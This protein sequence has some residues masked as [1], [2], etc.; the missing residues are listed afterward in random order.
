M[1]LKA[2]VLFSI[3][4]LILANDIVWHKFCVTSVYL[5]LKERIVVFVFSKM[6]Y[7]T[8]GVLVKAF[9]FMLACCDY[10]IN[11][12]GDLIIGREK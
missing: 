4:W 11:I 5:L 3:K 2:D 8:Y 9:W 12:N 6:I 10:E 1:Y 7:E